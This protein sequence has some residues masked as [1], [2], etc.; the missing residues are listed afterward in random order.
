MFALCGALQVDHKSKCKNQTTKAWFC[1]RF[2]FADSAH[3]QMLVEQ[4]EGGNIEDARERGS[5]WEKE[6]KKKLAVLQRLFE[7]KFLLVADHQLEGKQYIS[8]Q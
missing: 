8:L 7:I 1:V 4:S 2:C 5:V 6:E 3:S